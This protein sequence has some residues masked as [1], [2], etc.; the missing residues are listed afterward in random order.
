MHDLR[1]RQRRSEDRRRRARADARASARRRHGAQPRATITHEHVTHGTTMVTTHHERTTDTTHRTSTTTR[2]ARAAALHY[3]HRRGA[4][5]RA[6]HDASRGWCRS[7][8]TSCRRTTSTRAQPRVPRRARHLRAQPRVE[9]RA[10][11]RR[12]CWCAPSSGCCA[13][14]AG[15]GDRRRPADHHRRRAHPRHRRARRCRSTPAR[16]ATSTRR[17]SRR[18]LE[19]LQPADGLGAD[20][21][22]RRQ[23]RLPGRLRPRRGAQGGRAVGD[24]RR[25]QAAE[26]P[27]H[28]PAPRR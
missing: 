28:V 17:W 4:R 25:G 10:R 18:A 22:E 9:P 20:D 12:R 7:S 27:R 23:P 15:R 5:P 21:R 24:R 3:G 13:T 14:P 11:A 16:A 6:R 19:R 2:T 26:V 1:L 8:R